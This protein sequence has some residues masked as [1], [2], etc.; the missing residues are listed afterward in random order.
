MNAMPAVAQPSRKSASVSLTPRPQRRSMTMKIIVP[1]GR[2]TKASAK[3]RKD[4]SIAV[5]GSAKG[6]ITRGK[7][8]TEASAKTKKSKNSEL[9]PITTPTAM[10]VMLVWAVVSTA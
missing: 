4:Q 1:K 7:T 2:A 5:S 3:S 6:N 9:R 10:S 8:S